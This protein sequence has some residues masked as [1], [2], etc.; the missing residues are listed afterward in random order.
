MKLL[1]FQFDVNEVIPTNVENILF[2]P[3]FAFFVVDFIKKERNTKYYGVFLPFFTNLCIYEV[4]N[5]AIH[6]NENIYIDTWIYNL[7]SVPQNT[8]FLIADIII[9][10]EAHAVWTRSRKEAIVEVNNKTIL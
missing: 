7:I 3:F 1:N 2:L 10:S 8:R 5:G 9:S 6:M 4:L